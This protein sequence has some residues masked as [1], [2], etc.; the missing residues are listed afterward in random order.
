MNLALAPAKQ[1]IIDQLH[2]FYAMFDLQSRVSLINQTGATWL[3]FKSPEK[4]MGAKYEEIPAPAGKASDFFYHIDDLV[5]TRKKSVFY[6]GYYGYHDTYRVIQG[7]KSPFFNQERDIIGI[8][9]QFQDVTHL[10]IVNKDHLLF[11]PDYLHTQHDEIKQ[12]CY[13]F[14][15]QQENQLLSEREQECLFFLLRRKTAKEIARILS[16][17]PRTV[18]THM[19]RIRLKLQCPSTSDLLEKATVENFGC[20]LPL[21]YLQKIWQKHRFSRTC[22]ACVT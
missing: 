12:F 6:L 5:L 10:N 18:E 13:L 15:E 16:L 8:S 17:S 21:K 22:P 19:E 11:E 3:G 20:H 9:C 4:A 7:V 1:D 2:G 14:F